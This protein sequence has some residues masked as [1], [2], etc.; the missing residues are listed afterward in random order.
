VKKPTLTTLLFFLFLGI[1]LPASAQS[2]LS[3]PTKSLECMITTDFYIVH[4][5]AYQEPKK[6]GKKRHTFK[7]FC[8]ELPEAGASFL[9]IDF[10]DRDLR[11]MPI[12]MQV[13]ELKENPEG[14]EMIDGKIIAQLPAQ[15]YKTGVAQIQVDFPKPGHYA[16]VASVGDDM[17]ADKIR[18]PLRVGIGSEFHWSS[19]FPYLMAIALALIAYGFY[20]FFLFLHKRRARKKD[21][22]TA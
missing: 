15:N 9:A 17:F 13:M 6:D 20:R 14:G 11:K 4:L 19:L 21:N 12:G 10:I 22:P 16:L 7:P 18:I 5:S 1:H 3:D 8:Q 2:P